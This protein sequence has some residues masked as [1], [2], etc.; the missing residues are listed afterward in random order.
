M[1]KTLSIVAIAVTG[2]LAV[3]ACT[4]RETRIIQPAVAVPAA[5]VTGTTVI[6]PD[7]DPDIIVDIN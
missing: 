3:S 2:A 6:V 4:T 7:K 5:P 1:K